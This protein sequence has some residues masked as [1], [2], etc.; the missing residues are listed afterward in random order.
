MVQARSVGCKVFLDRQ[1]MTG[2]YHQWEM[3]TPEAA[4]RVEDAIN[5]ALADAVT[6]AVDEVVESDHL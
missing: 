5:E 1:D 6:A 3:P 2:C 4:R